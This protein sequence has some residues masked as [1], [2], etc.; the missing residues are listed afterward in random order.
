[1]IEVS[2]VQA[3]VPTA[4]QRHRS[5]QLTVLRLPVTVTT[6]QSARLSITHDGYNLAWLLFQI[7]VSAISL[8]QNTCKYGIK[9]YIKSG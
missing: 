3:A 4:R 5:H 7:N 6:V 2:H 1:M 9:K 8:V